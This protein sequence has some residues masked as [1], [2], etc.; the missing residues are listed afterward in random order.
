MQNFEYHGA[1]TFW[2]L[3]AFCLQILAFSESTAWRQKS[4]ENPRKSKIGQ[5][6]ENP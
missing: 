1:Q 2:K 3:F 4:A 6:L 5:N